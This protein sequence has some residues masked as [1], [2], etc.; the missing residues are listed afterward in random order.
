ML[1]TLAIFRRVKGMERGHA[2][3]F[4]LRQLE[5]ID[6]PKRNVAAVTVANPLSDW[7]DPNHSWHADSRI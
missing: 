4:G 2:F 3:T 1:A 5:E 6:L 7:C